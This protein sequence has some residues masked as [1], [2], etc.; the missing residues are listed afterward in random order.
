MFCRSPASTFP[1]PSST[2]PEFGQRW[3]K[4]QSWWVPRSPDLDLKKPC[5]GPLLMLMCFFRFFFPPCQV[6]VVRFYDDMSEIW[7]KMSEK[8]SEEMSEDMPEDM[9]EEMSIE[10]SEDMSKDM[11]EEMSKDMSEDMSKGMTEKNARK[12]V[13]RY[14]RINVRRNVK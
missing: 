13:R 14:V 8:M 6:R 5:F 10:M 4:P 3:E 11:S 1:V 12:N 2:G 9:P 7:Q